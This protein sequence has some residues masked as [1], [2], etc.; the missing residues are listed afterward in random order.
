MVSTPVAGCGQARRPVAA[1][2]RA[3]SPGTALGESRS[4]CFP[5]RKRQ[6]FGS[7]AQR[8]QMIAPPL[9]HFD[10]LGEFLALVV[11]APDFIAIAVG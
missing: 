3:A 5:A 1:D 6:D 7:L 10:A 11:P 8:V 9:R 2:R 4:A